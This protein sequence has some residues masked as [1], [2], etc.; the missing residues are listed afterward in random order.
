MAVSLEPNT[1]RWWLQRLGTQLMED[2][3][4]L[5]L[6]ECYRSG[7]HPLPQGHERMRE[8]FRILQ[9][10]ARSNYT[11]LV[12]ESVKERAK[13]LGIRRGTQTLVNPSSQLRWQANGLDAESGIGHSWCLTFGRSYVIIGPPTKENFDQPVISIEDPRE[14]IHEP[15]PLRRRVSLAGLKLY[16]D[17]V[18][19]QH[20]AVLYLGDGTV[21]YFYRPQRKNEGQSFRKFD[22]SKWLDDTS[23]FEG[24]S[25]DL[26]INRCPV[27]PFIN[28]PEYAPMG[29]GEF[30]DVIDIQDR[31]NSTILDRMVISRMQ[32]YR[33]RWMKGASLTDELGNVRPPFDPG[34]DLLWAVEDADVEFGDFDTTDIRPLLDATKADVNDLAAITRTPPHYLLGALVNVSGDALTAAETG[35]V[36]KVRDHLVGWG[37]SWEDVDRIAGLYLGEEPDPSASMVW[38]DPQFRSRAEMA[39]AAV[40]E[41]AV[42]VPWNMLMER[43]GFTPDDI[44]RMRSER[45]ADAML[46]AATAPVVSQPA[47]GQ[48]GNQR[49]TNSASG[50]VANAPGAAPT[51]SATGAGGTPAGP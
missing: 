24:G 37:E 3:P 42:G 25:V 14:V 39:D 11:G 1:P 29:F 35:L 40:K 13:P 32:A 46:Q 45:A 15:H 17:S 50:P 49:T 47:Q 6:L 2:R 36:S 28:R 4:R 12:I 16:V 8:A 5:D 20:K 22:Q 31:I 48:P 43:L 34:A 9:R 51:G 23:E 21:H 10:K 7:E 41:Q 18:M 19:G 27:V 44:K 30:E 38:S 26:G 33:Q